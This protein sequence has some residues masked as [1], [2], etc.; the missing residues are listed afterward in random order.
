MLQ[1][2]FQ[3]MLA[4]RYRGPALVLRLLKEDAYAHRWRYA[5]AFALM[6]IGA[7]A[8]A[9]S[10]YLLG[11]SINQ[12][13]IHRNP[14]A[15]VAIGIALTLV[16]ALRGAASYG[17]V[18]ILSRISNRIVADNQRRLFDKL[19]NENVGFFADRHSSEF[20]ARLTT[21]A[22]AVSQVLNLL[23]TSVGRDFFSLVALVGVMVVQDPLMSLLTFVIAPPAVF[24]LRK[25]IRRTYRIAQ[26]QFAGGT[27][28]IETMQEALQGLT[29][30]KAFTLENEMRRRLDANVVEVEAQSNKMAR[31]SSRASPLME[32]LGGI[33]V[34]I[35]IIYGG[36]RVAGT[37]ATPGEF[38]SFITAFMLAY[39]PAKRLA[40]LNFELN[41]GFV[42]VRVLFE[43]LDTPPTEPLD[44]RNPPLV[45]SRARVEF[46]DV[47]FCYRPN[48]PAISGVSFVAE[49]GKVTALVGP[50]G[51]G[52]STI[53]RL[54]LRLYEPDSGI[55]TIDGQNIAQVS[56]RS[57]RQQIAYVGQHVHLFRGTVRENIA[58]GRV[59]ASEQ[60]IIAAAKAAHA[61][62]FIMAFPAGYD[63]PVG[64]HGL[65]LSG[66]QRQRIAIARALIKDVPLI[67]LDEATAALD[68]ESERYVQ[69]AVAELCKNRTT[70]VVAHR[71]STIMHADRILV[72]ESG[73]IVDSG[74][75]DELLH[76]GGRYA[77]FH[78]LQLR[79]HAPTEPQTAV[80]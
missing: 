15:I 77:S 61:H 69:D 72:I 31:V 73:A 76:R 17:H 79:E 6:V 33:A 32:T 64:E 59:G 63:T 49:P 35:I 8:T 16:I 70:I 62:D 36:Y 19:L 21:G 66:G 42:G 30:V 20:I 65:Q 41:R 54:I 23:I 50:S 38:F 22:A 9:A 43:V 68:S 7:A 55:I 24:L 47:T 56:R 44:D 71:L 48:E 46:A 12:A 4:D 40:R 60:D 57:L 78:R 34:A 18:V 80:S 28:I 67:L 75:H 5:A 51:G 45:I 29:A 10:A 53:L 74:R 52:K 3:S 58:F 11:D 27:R 1:S 39:D 26:S 2:Y 13:Y 14:S 25:L 37:G